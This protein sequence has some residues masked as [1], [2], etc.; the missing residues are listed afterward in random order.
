MLFRSVAEKK[1]KEILMANITKHNREHFFS[2]NFFSTIVAELTDNIK[3]AIDKVKI[4]PGFDT[5][6]DRWQNLL[7]LQ[8][9]NNFLNNN[10]NLTYP[11][12]EQYIQIL[13]FI[14]QCQ[15]NS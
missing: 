9:V 4:E 15:K 10:T 13:K 7:Q 1:E 3:T 11:T 2:T 6:I 5:W 14:K 12:Q 8:Q